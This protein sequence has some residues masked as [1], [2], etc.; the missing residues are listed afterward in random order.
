MGKKRKIGSW[1]KLNKLTKAVKITNFKSSI[2][3]S[4][5]AVG[6]LASAVTVGYFS[7]N[8]FND[9]LNESDFKHY[10]IKDVRDNFPVFVVDGKYVPIYDS[11]TSLRM[12]F[13]N[14]KIERMFKDFIVKSKF[15]GFLKYLIDRDP[16]NYKVLGLYKDIKTTKP[17]DID[18]LQHNQISSNIIYMKFSVKD[19]EQ[20]IPIPAAL[21]VINT[22]IFLKKFF[23]FKMLKASRWRKV[24]SR[25]DIWYRQAG[26]LPYQYFATNQ[27]AN[28]TVTRDLYHQVND[29]FKAFI[30]NEKQ[31]FGKT[32]QSVE[33]IIN[34]LNYSLT[35]FKGE[36]PL[37]D[38]FINTKVQ[39]ATSNANL[40]A[41]QIIDNKLS[42]NQPLDPERST[43]LA[44]FSIGFMPKNF[45]VEQFKK[46][47]SQ[48][49]A[50]TTG[51]V[52][53]FEYL[54]V[55][56]KYPILP[57]ATVHSDK[58]KEQTNTLNYDLA[59]K[60]WNQILNNNYANNFVFKNFIYS[61]VS[62]KIQFDTLKAN[63]LDEIANSSYYYHRFVNSTDADQFKPI[64]TTGE[65][66]FLC[67]IT[68]IT[69]FDQYHR[70]NWELSEEIWDHDRFKFENNFALIHANLANIKAISYTIGAPGLKRKAGILDDTGAEA[71]DIYDYAQTFFNKA[72]F[73][74][75]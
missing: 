35:L 13:L 51:A 44:K 72:S 61:S 1:H 69:F 23:E 64:L 47:A 8:I 7:S 49:F 26:Y 36:Q 40:M 75:S 31:E 29:N 46:D 33:Q 2:L 21:N 27:T 4:S 5:L 53:D 54:D 56:N 65:K 20:K 62:V 10:D 37:N 60:K 45:D 74:D 41:Q 25:D 9:L 28:A 58:V 63:L 55:Y 43:N 30:A 71:K 15:S 66:R 24:A 39:T 12:E 48:L 14:K 32:E 34:N 70:E 67:G 11:A 22:E 3:F 38:E 57:F 6:Y 17:I 50:S 59:A 42:E 16:N 68:S 19:E 18:D 73:T 52:A